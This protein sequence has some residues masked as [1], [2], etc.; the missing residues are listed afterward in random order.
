MRASLTRAIILDCQGVERHCSSKARRFLA[1]CFP[2]TPFMGD[3]GLAFVRMVGYGKL[4][5]NVQSNS[6]IEYARLR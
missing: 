4:H 3:V 2:E 6:L 1:E 5:R